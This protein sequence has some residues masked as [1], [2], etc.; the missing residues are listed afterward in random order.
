MLRLGFTSR[1]IDMIILCVSTVRYFITLNGEEF[2]IIILKRGLQHGDP[3]SLSVYPIFL[4]FD[5]FMS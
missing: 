5:S 2:G 1:W 4:R 3:L